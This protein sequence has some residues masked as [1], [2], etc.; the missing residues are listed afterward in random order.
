[1][2]NEWELS[3]TTPLVSYGKLGD[4]PLTFVRLCP[5]CGKFVKADDFVEDPVAG[6]DNATCAKCG[7]VT[8]LLC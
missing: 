4:E 2:N 7:R 5:N 3:P 1:M 8:M 6:E